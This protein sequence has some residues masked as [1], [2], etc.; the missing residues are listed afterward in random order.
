MPLLNILIL[1]SYE[2]TGGRFGE[3]SRN[4]EGTGAVGGVL[5]QLFRFSQAYNPV[6]TTREKLGETAKKKY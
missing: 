5:P 2:K 4:A 3:R 6:F 1:S